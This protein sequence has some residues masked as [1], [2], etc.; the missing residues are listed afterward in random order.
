MALLKGP[1]MG[2]KIFPR[3][4]DVTLHLD[5][6]SKVNFVCE[7]FEFDAAK[8]T[9]TVAGMPHMLGHP[10]LKALEAKRVVAM[11]YRYIRLYRIYWA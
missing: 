4:I 2:L 7:S 10:A 1:K 9:Y 3:K 8:G 11:T 6:G 5:T